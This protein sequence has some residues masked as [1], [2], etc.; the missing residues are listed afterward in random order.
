MAS[1]DGYSLNEKIDKHYEEVREE[2][3]KM[4]VMFAELYGY[5][6]KIESVKKEMSNGIQGDKK[7]S[8]AKSKAT[9]KEKV[10]N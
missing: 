1:L 2:L 5:I 9:K 10:L 6:S 3:M 8:K 4:K 7:K